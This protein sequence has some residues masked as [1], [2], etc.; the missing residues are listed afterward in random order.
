MASRKRSGSPMYRVSAVIVAAVAGGVALYFFAGDEVREAVGLG[1]AI[2]APWLLAFLLALVARPSA[3][4]RGNLWLA[5]VAMVAL[6]LG[7][8]GL[9]EPDS[10]AAGWFTMDGE[11]SLGGDVSHAIVGDTTWLGVVRLLGILIVVAAAA[12]PARALDLGREAGRR[13]PFV[14]AFL[15]SVAQGIAGWYRSRRAARREEPESPPVPTPPPQPEPAPVRDWDRPSRDL[16]KDEPGEEVTEEELGE[17][18]ETIRRTLA[19]YD[20]EVEVGKTWPGPTVTIYG[21]VPGWVRRY[22]RVRLLDENGR[23]KVDESGRPVTERQEENRTRV[24]VESILARE[25][26]LALALKTPSI[27]IETPVMGESL[28]GIEI[29]NRNPSVV[30]VGSV[31][32]SEEF[33]ELGAKA[34]LPVALGKAAGGDTVVIDL[35]RMPHLLIAGATGSGKSVCVNA[36][37]S[38]LIAEKTPAELR[39]LLIDPKRVELTPY[40]GIPHLLTPVVVESDQV[41]PLL[42]GM[43]DEMLE[44]YRRLE[45]AGVRNIEAYNEGRHDKMPFIVVAVDELADLMMT[46]AA[47]VEQLLCRLAQLARATG[48]HLI[49]ATQRPSV[50]VVTGLI[51]ANF[52]SRIAFGVSSQVDSRTILDAAGADKLLGRGDMLYLPMDAAKPMR[53][54]GVYISD[55]EVSDLV[56]FWKTTPRGRLAEIRLRPVEDGRRDGEA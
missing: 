34:S 14:Y 1:V 13:A 10:G 8:M 37:I 42:K 16:V 48:I 51:K 11:V 5:S 28:L 38:C 33:A 41:V 45:E 56:T 47:E 27:R 3:L 12:A 31:M 32:E 2:V 17:Q 21:L 7:A 53:V 15:L 44:R 40:N 54:Q 29:P 24:K 6:A 55:P 39:L 26:D 25:K 30:T 36:I 9:F 4:R 50:D 35:A 19:E 20:I 46:A 49:I 18:G 52:P 23:P 43:V 22:R